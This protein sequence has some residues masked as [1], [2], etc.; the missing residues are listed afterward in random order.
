MPWTRDNNAEVLRLLKELNGNQVNRG[1]SKEQSGDGL[2]E[3]IG[4][5]KENVIDEYATMFAEGKD[6]SWSVYHPLER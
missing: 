2:R 5:N 1:D 4:A 3:Q 6:Q